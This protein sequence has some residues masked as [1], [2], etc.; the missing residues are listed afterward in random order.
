MARGSAFLLQLKPDTLPIAVTSAHVAAPH[1]YPQYFKQDW[2]KHVTDHDCLTHLQAHS[3]QENVVTIPLTHGFRHTTLDVAA[4]HLTP[5]ETPD[6]VTSLTLDAV[7]KGDDVVMHGYRLMGEAGSGKEVVVPASLEGT[8]EEIDG[9]RLFVD[10]G[11]DYSEMGMCGGPLVKNGKCV[12]VLE[13]LIPPL[14][15]GEDGGSF[16]HLRGYSVFIGGEELDQFVQQVN[17]HVSV[18]HGDASSSMKEE[19]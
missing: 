14:K 5:D 11:K 19:T 3:T 17:S 16:K 13:G 4:F 18:K 8:V 9:D 6:N 1:S 12:G 15:E 2:L 7:S 10:T